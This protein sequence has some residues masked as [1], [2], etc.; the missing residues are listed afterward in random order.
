MIK[1]KSKNPK[2]KSENPK[3]KSKT[4]DF[5]LPCLPA[6]RELLPFWF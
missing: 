4:F 2:V 3:L 5:Y 6:G 1:G